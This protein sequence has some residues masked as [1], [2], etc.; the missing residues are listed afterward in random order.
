MI[1]NDRQY[2][3]DNNA[4]VR[5]KNDYVGFDTQNNVAQ[6]GYAYE[7][8]DLHL[9]ER[10][11]AS[12]VSGYDRLIDEQIVTTD[13]SS[14]N[15]QSDL[16][17]SPTTLQFIGKERSYVYQDL[18]NRQKQEED[19]DVNYKINTKSKVMIAVYAL[20]V[21]TIFTLIILN[22]RLLKTMDTSINEQEARIEA[23]QDTNTQLFSQFEFVSSDEEVARRAEAMGM[24]KNG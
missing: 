20:V 2:R 15:T 24:Q 13:N 14:V 4:S 21:L 18:N 19:D 7:D 10:D 8:S 12:K 22:T 3:N 16:L 9:R 23:L 11:Q 6:N 1:N 17:P 5:Y